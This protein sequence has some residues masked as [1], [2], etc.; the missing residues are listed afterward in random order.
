MLGNLKTQEV[1]VEYWLQDLQAN[2][3]MIASDGSVKDNMGLY[4]IILHTEERELW[5][6][7]PYDC[8][9]QDKP[10]ELSAPLYCDNIS[11]VC[12]SNRNQLCGVTAHLV[13]DYDI[14]SKIRTYRSCGI[15]IKAEWVK[16]HQDDNSPL[17]NLPLSAQFNC[18]VDNNAALFM[19]NHPI[20]LKPTANPI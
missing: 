12:S 7:G 13:A 9:T 14:L 4:S 10:T 1:D 8:S 17:D 20:E 16:A 6:Q 19:Q 2:K 5:L 11:A 15:D 18:M 3:V